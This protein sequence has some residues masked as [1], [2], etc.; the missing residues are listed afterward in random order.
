MDIKRKLIEDIEKLTDERM[1]EYIYTNVLEKT[2]ILNQ[3]YHEWKKS[4]TEKEKSLEKLVGALEYLFEDMYFGHKSIT[5]DYM[6]RN[7]RHLSFNPPLKL[8]KQY[9][10][11]AVNSI[12]EHEEKA[13][14]TDIISRKI[15]VDE[16]H[17]NDKSLILHEM[18]H[19]YE[20]ILEKR[21]SSSECVE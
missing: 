3:K 1:I 6:L 15:V 19:A 2:D 21:G 7:E 20:F 12:E 16:R 14:Y 10:C 18:I 17:I 13:A 9:F 11:L 4:Q 5:G 8:D